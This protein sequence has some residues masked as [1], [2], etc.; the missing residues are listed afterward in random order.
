[1]ADVLGT[2]LS[3]PMRG[4]SSGGRTQQRSLRPSALPLMSEVLPAA[5][6][7]SPHA[8]LRQSH[9]QSVTADDSLARIRTWYH[10]GARGTPGA[11]PNTVTY[12]VSPTSRAHHFARADR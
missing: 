10:M 8:N 7:V 9:A 4:L 12:I 1:M 5:S 6:T 11:P 3:W 2:I